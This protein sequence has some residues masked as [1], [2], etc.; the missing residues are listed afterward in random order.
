SGLRLLTHTVP[1]LQPE[2]M[3]SPWPGVAFTANPAL[4]GSRM[5]GA[6]SGVTR[7]RECTFC[8]NTHRQNEIIDE[9]LEKIPELREVSAERK[10]VSSRKCGGQE[11]ADYLNSAGR[12]MRKWM[13]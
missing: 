13:L 11:L 7:R 5:G 12:S 8:R 2:R 9:L 10:K 4:R 1:W 3:R 6:H